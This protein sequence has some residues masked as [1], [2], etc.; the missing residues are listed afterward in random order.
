MTNL[1]DEASFVDAV[2]GSNSDTAD[3][4]ESTGVSNINNLLGLGLA[5]VRTEDT[6]ASEVTMAVA[7]EYATSYPLESLIFARR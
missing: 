3:A 4:E 5:P 2:A 1:F 7:M 6:A